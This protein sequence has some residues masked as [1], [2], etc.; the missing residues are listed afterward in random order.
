MRTC[1]RF[2]SLVQ[3]ISTDFLRRPKVVEITCRREHF[4]QY[5]VTSNVPKVHAFLGFDH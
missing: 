1:N 3:Q 2:N 4:L 5:H